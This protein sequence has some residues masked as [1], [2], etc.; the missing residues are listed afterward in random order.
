MDGSP[1]AS[2]DVASFTTPSGGVGVLPAAPESTE[3]LERAV[4]ILLG[5]P[6]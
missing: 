5:Q 1:D 6:S 4:A 2:R 3:V